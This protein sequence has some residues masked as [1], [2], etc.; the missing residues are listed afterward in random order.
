[1][2]D[3]RAPVFLSVK[4]EART[5]QLSGPTETQ[6][7]VSS[8]GAGVRPLREAVCP[9][10]VQAPGRPRGSCRAERRGAPLGMP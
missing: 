1:M 6:T 9:S 4:W 7:Q 3:P 5:G 2:M 10:G 8:A